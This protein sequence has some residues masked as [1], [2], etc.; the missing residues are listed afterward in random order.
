MH[1]AAGPR[2]RIAGPPREHDFR[3][4]V[5]RPHERLGAHHADNARG[6]FDGRR[7]EHRHVFQ[8]AYAAFLQPSADFAFF[9]VGMDQRHLE[10]EAVF[11]RDFARELGDLLQV[12]IAA[13]AAATADHQRDFFLARR[14]QHEPQVAPHRLVRV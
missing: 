6:A 13:G 9:L 5:E 10:V 3:A 11:A 8:G 1:G 4:V 12:R 7:I 14:I 2:C